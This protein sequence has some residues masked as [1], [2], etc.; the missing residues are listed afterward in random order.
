[1]DK[2]KHH[3]KAFDQRLESLC[4]E[5]KPSLGIVGIASS[6]VVQTA[7]FCA[8]LGEDFCR[9]AR[10]KWVDTVDDFRQTIE[11]SKGANDNDR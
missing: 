10:Q 3:Q 7:R 11:K 5:F 2:T 6:L 4:E 9:V 8:V 1:M